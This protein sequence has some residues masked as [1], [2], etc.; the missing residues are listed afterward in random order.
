MKLK[1]LRKREK[2]PVETADEVKEKPEKKEK[3]EGYVLKKN[4]AMKVLRWVLWL[5]LLFVFVRGI[6][7]IFQQDKEQQVEA[8]IRDFRQ[9]YS[10]FTN[11]NEEVMAFAQNFAK[12]YFTYES[13]GEAAYKSRLAS[14]V[15]KDFFEKSVLDFKANAAV[16][17]AQAYRLEDYSEKQKDVYVLVEIVYTKQVLEE[18]QGYQTQTDTSLVTLK[19]PVYCQESAY[20]VEC[21]PMI[22]TDA[23]NLE[24][25]AA[26]EYSG[27]SLSETQQAAMAT[28]IGNFLKAYVEQDASIISYYLDASVDKTLFAGLD[29]RFMFTGLESLK[30]YQLTNGDILCLVEYMVQDSVNDAKVLQ[31]INISVKN[32]GEKYYITAMNTRI[33]NLNVN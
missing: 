11:Q 29:G 9:N 30:C 26:E 14:Y 18:G 15:S 3:S 10:T 33:G 12:E 27:I 20:V 13:R 31:K 22:V 4:T 7:S 1:Q 19:V 23:N 17:Y 28:F 6:F 5:M 24:A 21:V 2:I 16:S 32:V 25:Y 8:L